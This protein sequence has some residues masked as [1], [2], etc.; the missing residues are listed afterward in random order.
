METPALE[1]LMRAYFHQDFDLLGDLWDNVDAFVAGAPQLAPL[2]PDE[3]SWV[4]RTHH[5][6]AEL[7]AFLDGLGCELSLADEEGGYRGCLL[8]IARRVQRDLAGRH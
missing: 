1:H 4:L 3:V 8:E 7:E 2:L 5:T 6:D